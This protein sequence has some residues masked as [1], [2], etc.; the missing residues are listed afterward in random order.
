[1]AEVK[2]PDEIAILKRAAKAAKK[3][4]ARTLPF[5]RAGISERE[6]AGIMEG[7]ALEIPGVSGLAFPAIIASGPNSAMPHA[8][9]TDRKIK[10]GDLVTV[11][12]G[13]V[14]HGYTS[15]MTRTFVIGEPDET[16]RKI[17]RSVLRSQKAGLSSAKAGMLCSE[18][19]AVCRGSIEKDGYGE[20][21]IH[22]TGHGIGREVHEDPRIGKKSTSRLESGMAVT[23]EPGIYIEGMGGVR[24]EDTVIIN[25][26]GC[27]VI[28]KGI[29]KELTYLKKF[30]SVS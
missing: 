10:T 6:I 21:F 1:M 22:T 7:F 29:S 16:Q 14:F 30:G 5:I 9:L 15:D 19:D 20:Y 23:I 27:E 18:L 3:V 25:E 28:S 2:T 24:I 17:Y 13:V 4:F 8:E 12:F 11:D 26:S